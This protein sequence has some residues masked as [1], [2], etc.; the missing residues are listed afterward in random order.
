MASTVSMGSG[1]GAV[2]QRGVAVAELRE[3]RMVP[4]KQRVVQADAQALGTKGLQEFCHDVSSEG[5][6][7]DLPACGYGF[8]QAESAEALYAL[9]VAD[10]IKLVRHGAFERELPSTTAMPSQFCKATL[11]KFH[12]MR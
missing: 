11:E 6:V 2:A 8:K 9:V 5:G 1:S 12:G 7:G 4:I 10:A 3:V